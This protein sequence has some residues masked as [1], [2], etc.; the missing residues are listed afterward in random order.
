[1]IVSFTWFRCNIIDASGCLDAGAP[2]ASSVMGLYPP[3]F[4]AT[5][6][7]RGFPRAPALAYT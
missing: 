3:D 5:L 1:M 6:K 7:S 2:I 4:I